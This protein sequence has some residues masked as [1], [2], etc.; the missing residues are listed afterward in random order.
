MS[1]ECICVHRTEAVAEPDV[2][3]G[4]TDVSMSDE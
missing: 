2:V 1:C 4:E 3:F